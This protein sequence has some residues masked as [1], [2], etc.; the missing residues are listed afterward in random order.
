MPFLISVIQA[1]NDL[2]ADLKISD[3][4]SIHCNTLTYYLLFKINLHKYIKGFFFY[5]LNWKQ[6]S[7]TFWCQFSNILVIYY[8]NLNE[9]YFKLFWIYY[10]ILSYAYAYSIVFLLKMTLHDFCQKF[11][12]F[13]YNCSKY[14]TVGLFFVN[15]TNFK[16]IYSITQLAHAIFSGFTPPCISEC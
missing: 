11:L 5:T 15:R 4:T 2:L 14:W 13:F 6:P 7:F 10:F 8:N 16:N 12:S 3:K 1:K 9:I